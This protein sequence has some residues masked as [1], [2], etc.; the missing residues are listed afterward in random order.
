MIQEYIRVGITKKCGVTFNFGFGCNSKYK[1]STYIWKSDNLKNFREISKN[2]FSKLC[3]KHNKSNNLFRGYACGDIGEDNGLFCTGYFLTLE[4]A[5]RN[6]QEFI[7][8]K[9]WHYF[10]YAHVEQLQDDG[11]F[12]IV[13]KLYL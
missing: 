2:E 10:A 6:T 3:F 5:I 12:K 7:D 4:D 8:E 1:W 13:K 9:W 11:T